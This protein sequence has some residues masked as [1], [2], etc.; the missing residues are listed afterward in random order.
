MSANS[1]SSISVAAGEDEVG[2]LRVSASIA[3][4]ASMVLERAAGPGLVAVDDANDIVAAVID[5]DPVAEIEEDI[6]TSL[7]P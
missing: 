1:V 7:E 6:V 3:L 5:N 2:L 4:F